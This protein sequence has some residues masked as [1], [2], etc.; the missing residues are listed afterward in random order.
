VNRDPGA[1]GRFYYSV[2]TTG[3]YCRPACPS[4]LARRENV[5]FHATSRDAEKAGFRPCRRCRPTEESLAERRA[6]AVARACRLIEEADE[7][8][9]LD[10]L[11]TS[12]GLSR[13]HFHR[14]FKAHTGVTPKGY[15]SAHRARRVREELARSG[16]VTEAIYGAGYRSNGRFYESSAEVL[17]MTPKAF[18]AGGDGASI[19]FA[20]GECWLGRILVAASDKG[21][22]AIMFGDD[23]GELSR[24][25][26]GRFPNASLIGGDAE[27]ERLVAEVVR[28]VGDPSAGLDL[29][30]DIRGSAFQRRV[31]EALREI[32]PGTTAS[33]SEIAERI[34]RPKSVRAVGRACGANDLAVAIPCHRVVR[35]DGSLSG[36]RWGLERKGELLRRERESG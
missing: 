17:G 23:P 33:Y 2:R 22:C 13:H 29:P 3:V 16:T 24:E 12:V 26:R 10:D 18:R 19:R 20:I 27:F 8:P 36:Y 5:R 30:L 32:P 21:V 28:F 34:G 35:S 25:L 11:A 31:W 9:S 14:I 6:S 7:A 15:A 4:R 1:D